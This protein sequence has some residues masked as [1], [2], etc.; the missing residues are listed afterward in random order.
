MASVAA[1]PLKN[2]H[3]LRHLVSTQIRSG[4]PRKQLLG[5]RLDHSEQ[6]LRILHYVSKRTSGSPS[7]PHTGSRFSAPPPPPFIG[8][9]PASPS[10]RHRSS[11]SSAPPTPPRPPLRL[12]GPHS[13]YQVGRPRHPRNPVRR[14]P[15]RADR[16][17]EPLRTSVRAGRTPV[18]RQGKPKGT[19]ALL[20]PPRR[21]R[22]RR[23]S[24]GLTARRR[25]PQV[26]LI[27]ETD[28]E[29]RFSS[30]DWKTAEDAGALAL[31]A[32]LLAETH[33]R[34]LSPPPRARPPLS[35][36]P[37]LTAPPVPLARQA[38]RSRSRFWSRTRSRT[39]GRR[40]CRHSMS[41]TT[42]TASSGTTRFSRSTPDTPFQSQEPSS[43]T[44][45]SR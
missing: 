32:C 11:P 4:W 33:G 42:G 15:G 45:N 37:R 43:G 5:T 19:P 12:H 44:S 35:P 24:K 26:R 25:R 20:R 36:A 22:S 28:P 21:P 1:A 41:T 6:L 10:P 30:V 3:L 13:L 8:P 39:H 29:L 2:P 7:H 16:N 14:P 34:S 23:V 18:R 38:S 31:A 27:F 40:R 9:H 17:P